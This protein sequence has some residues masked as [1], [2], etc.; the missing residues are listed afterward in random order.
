MWK[1][2]NC[3]KENQ[4]NRTHC[5]SCETPIDETT[6][7]DDRPPSPITGT[8]KVAENRATYDQLQISPILS[9]RRNEA[10]STDFFISALKIFAWVALIAGIIGCIWLWSNAPDDI[11]ILKGLRVQYI[12]NAISLAIEGFVVWVL[13]NVVAAMA[14][15]IEMIRQKI[16]RER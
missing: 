7:K 4:N 13:F 10:A 2:K 11:G 12:T 3:G 6:V 8:K 1:C 5:W 15:N 16:S 9:S 14:E